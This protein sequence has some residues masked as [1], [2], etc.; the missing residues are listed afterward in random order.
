MT[1]SEIKKLIHKYLSGTISADEE[2]R[3]EQFDASLLQK[4]H[5]SFLLPKKE[6]D[7]MRKKL[8]SKI[9]SKKSSNWNTF[10]GVAATLAFVAALAY[11][12]MPAIVQETPKEVVKEFTA[13]TAWGQKMSITL[14]DGTKVRLNSGST[15][16]YPEKFIANTREVA[17]EGEA[18]F[19]VTKNAKKPF[20]ISSGAIKTKVLGTS[21]N[22]NTYDNKEDIAVTVA[23]GKVSVASNEEEVFLGPSEQGVF[24]KKEAKITKATIDINAV[25]QW[26]EGILHFGDATL[27]EVT[28]SLEKWYGVQFVFQN[29]ALEKC[30]LTATYDNESLH[31]ILESIIYAKKGI[32]YRYTN[33]HQIVLKGKCTN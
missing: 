16:R 11:F 26:K 7:K 19:E 13:T 25:L 10:I 2:R 27:K 1:E 18:F 14:A 20:I 30:R 33:D 15:L 29:K 23:S 12:F 8:V 32:S 28:A 4:N 31:A 6:E 5:S 9:A 17:L 24:N 21:F 3:L 22:I